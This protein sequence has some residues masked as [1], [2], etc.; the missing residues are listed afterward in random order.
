M[1]EDTAQLAGGDRAVRILLD[2][3]GVTRDIGGKDRR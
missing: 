3:T 1:T 2:E